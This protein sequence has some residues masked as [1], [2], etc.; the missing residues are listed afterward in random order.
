MS[1]RRESH[2]RGRDG[3]EIGLFV[4]DN[5][6]VSLSLS[7]YGAS[8]VSA[9]VPSRTG[10]RQDVVLGF[11][12]L[13]GYLGPHPFFG[14]TV[15]RF[16]NR[17]AGARFTIDGRESRLEANEGKNCL[18]GGSTA[19]DKRAWKGE[20]IASKDAVEFRLLSPDGDGGFPGRVDAWTRYTLSADNEV[21]IEFGAITDAPTHVNMTN[22]SYFNLA[23]QG[24]ILGH[25][26]QLSC[27]R[28]LEIDKDTLPTGRILEARGPMDFSAPK[29]LGAD[30][31]AMGMGYDHCYVIDRRGS[32]LV[33]AARVRDPASG[34]SLTVRSTQPGVQLYT[35]NYL[36]QSGGKGG[37]TYGHHA[38][39]CLETQ[40]FPD[41]PN[42]P[43]FPSSLLRPGEEYRETAVYA[44]A[45]D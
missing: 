43:E 31:A 2:G 44:F 35:G 30:M 22:H 23:G 11:D 19:W 3:A 39:F 4:I 13:E 25:E 21:W 6:T 40:H 36:N 12:S 26:L 27:T 37:K 10:G 29:A 15:G 1:V 8:L 34:R 16:A 45:W 18:H 42:R 14:V 32:G 20:A 33:Q 9:L 17:I 28:Y 41:S 5:G 7:E 24:D 38:G